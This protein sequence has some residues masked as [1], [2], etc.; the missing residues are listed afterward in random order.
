MGCG[1]LMGG[2]VV[3]MGGCVG[4]DWVVFFVVVFVFL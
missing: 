3:A 2:L 4:Y 1:V